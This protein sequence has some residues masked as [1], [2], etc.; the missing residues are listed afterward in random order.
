MATVNLNPLDKS[1]AIILTNNNLTAENTISSWAGIRATEGKSSGKW[2]WEM[3]LN[4]PHN[5]GIVG[6]FKSSS[7]LTT[8]AVDYSTMYN[9]YTIYNFIGNETLRCILDMDDIG[10]RFELWVDNIKTPIKVWTNVKTGLATTVYPFIQLIYSGNKIT[11]NFGQTKFKYP[12]PI[13]F[14]SYDNTKSDNDNWYLLKNN[15]YQI[16]IGDLIPCR[17]TALTSGQIGYFSEL[18]TSSSTLIPVTSS[19]TPDGSFY[20]VY[21]GKDYEGRKKFIADRNIQNSISWDTLN[22]NG[23]INGNS[24]K[25]PKINDRNND[26]SLIPIMTSSTCDIGSVSAFKSRTADT[27]SFKAFDGDPTTFW[28][29]FDGTSGY[30][31]MWIS[32]TFNKDTIVSEYEFECN[33]TTVTYAPVKW[34][35]EG[36]FDGINWFILDSRDNQTS[37]ITIKRRYKCEKICGLKYYR[38]NILKVNGGQSFWAVISSLQFYGV[39]NYIDSYIPSISLPSG[40]TS[41]TDIDNEWNQIIVNSTLNDTIVAG[42]NNIWNWQNCASFTSSR[43]LSNYIVRRGYS[44]ANAIYAGEASSTQTTNFADSNNG[45]R[46]ILLIERSTQPSIF[47][48]NLLSSSVHN[49]DTTLTGSITDLNN[50]TLKVQYKILINDNQ[51]YPTSEYTDLASSPVSINYT[52][53]NGLLTNINNKITI[54]VNNEANLISNYNF[55]VTIYNNIPNGILSLSNTTTHNTNIELTGNITDTDLDQISYRILIN[56]AEILPWNTFATDPY[57]DYTINANDL[58]V[59]NNTIEVDYKDSFKNVGLGSWTNTITRTNNPPIINIQYINGSIIGT[60]TDSD[61]DLT[62]Y[63]ILI[64]GTQKYPETTAY[65]DLKQVNNIDY[66]I[67]RNDILIGQNNIVTIFAKD[68]LNSVIGQE[69]SFMGDY[70]GLM[71]MDENQKFYTTDIGELLQY[72]DFGTITLGQIT[73]PVK[74]LVQNKYGFKIK[75]INLYVQNT[76]PNVNIELSKEENPF[77]PTDN[78]ILENTYNPNQIDYF[79][80]RLNTSISA[81][82][83]NGEF[84]I[85]AK[86]TPIN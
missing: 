25:I 70:V 62:Q 5:I 17:Y 59:G 51:I 65:S 52:I 77:I 37:D 47:T 24:I 18:G 11:A 14:K 30:S 58:I 13:N 41:S 66:Q 74:I 36:S 68:S 9:G 21:V 54:I 43:N 1:S 76:L 86:A 56:G 10:G 29:G 33:N 15:I 35:F 84:K 12:I 19:A 55:Y 50:P 28:F 31:S 67:N 85:Y 8:A 7:S 45:F 26:N 3:T 22:N 78:L 73:E 34:N 4:T 6:I 16:S 60:I 80:I 44:S 40:G 46:P 61:S 75:D 32:F 48:G 23:I 42:D 81:N 38:L 57:I 2:Y 71:F 39:Y 82:S 20:W 72:L 27:V 53:S 63:K 83:V 69:I 49:Q 64:N 79:Y